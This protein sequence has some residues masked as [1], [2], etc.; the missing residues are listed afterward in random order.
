VR[1]ALKPANDE[2]VQ[3]RRVALGCGGEVLSKAENWYLPA[4]LTPAMNRELVTQQTPFGR[5]VEGLGF[6]RRTLSVQY[7]DGSGVLRHRALLIARDGS[8][9][10]VVSEA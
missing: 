5:V 9:F 6:R 1:A 10:S 2:P 3:Y 7:G 8:P 4:R